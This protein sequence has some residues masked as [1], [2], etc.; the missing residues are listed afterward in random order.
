MNQT[1][2]MQWS[3]NV[4]IVAAVIRLIS[5][6][7]K[8]ELLCV[9]E[10]VLFGTISHDVLYRKLERGKNKESIWLATTK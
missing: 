7:V 5:I 1:Q 9:S 8:I 10:T 6:R 3:E 2:K 4:L